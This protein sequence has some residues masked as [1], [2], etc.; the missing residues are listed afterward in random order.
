MCVLLF[1]WRDKLGLKCAPTLCAT[2]E[3][4]AAVGNESPLFFVA[5]TNVV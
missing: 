5:H 3:N 1:F 4:T 2:S